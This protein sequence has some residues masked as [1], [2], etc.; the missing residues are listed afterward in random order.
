MNR[1]MQVQGNSNITGEEKRP[2]K[3]SAKSSRGKANPVAVRP[4]TY[5]YCKKSQV[6]M[7]YQVVQLYIPHQPPHRLVVVCITHRAG[8]AARGAGGPAAPGKSKMESA[9]KKAPKTV[10]KNLGEKQRP[11]TS[12]KRNALIITPLVIKYGSP[13]NTPDGIS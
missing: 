6:L 8:L 2:C 7:P 3:K 9:E 1:N 10:Q 11:H 4:G 13:L 5:R 12:E